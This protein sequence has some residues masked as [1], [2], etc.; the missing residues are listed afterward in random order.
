MQARFVSLRVTETWEMVERRNATPSAGIALATPEI[1]PQAAT[2]PPHEL[3]PTA[4]REPTE[5]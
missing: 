1:I 2:P 4:A 5:H 3:E